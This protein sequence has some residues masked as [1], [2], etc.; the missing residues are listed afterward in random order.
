MC[1]C[2]M[3]LAL[4]LVLCVGPLGSMVDAVEKTEDGSRVIRVAAI[5]FVPAKFD[6][7]ANAKRLET[8]FRQARRGGAVLAVAPEGALEG[9]VVN[10]IIGGQASPEQ[11][12]QVAV[13]SD[14][15]LIRRFR[16]LARELEMCLAFGFA[17]LQDEDVYNAAIFIDDRGKVR[18]KYH[19]MQFAEGYHA[20]WWFNRLGQLS[21]A[22]DTPLG[23]CGFLICNDRW[24]P[25]LARIPVLDGAQLLLIP[26]FGSRSLAQDE[27]VLKR[28]RENG[29]PVVEANVGVTLIV[30]NNQV[31]AVDR[32]EECVTFANITI[33][34]PAASLVSERDRVE[35]HFLEQRVEEMRRRYDRTMKRIR[36]KA[37]E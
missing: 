14:G 13:P 37:S 15:P 2:K 32:L 21:R 11:M 9:Y 12:K 22:F 5:S 24:N 35:Q 29:V 25:Q 6:L 34:P 20:S 8:M 1:A 36:S 23:R 28:G 26:S 3:M 18:G 4:S 16:N 10:E 17:E 30:D 33:R 31:A 19:K 27:A 7:L